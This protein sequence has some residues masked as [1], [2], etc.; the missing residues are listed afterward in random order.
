M[1]HVRQELE[2]SER[3]A[4]R[5]L[6]QARAVQRY[7]PQVRE[8]EKPLT[9]RL[10]ELAAVYGRYGTPRITAMLRG[11]GWIVN[12]KRIERMWRAEGLKVPQKQPSRGRL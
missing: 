10:V 8:D 3:R 11:E 4:C 1:I 5:V 2:V 6:G 12:H 7:T 9:A